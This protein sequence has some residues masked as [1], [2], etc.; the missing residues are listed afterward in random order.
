[1]K[2]A[3]FTHLPWPE[4]NRPG[5]LYESHTQQVIL[6]EELGFHSSSLRRLKFRVTQAL[7]RPAIAPGGFPNYPQSKRNAPANLAGAF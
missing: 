2:F 1:M 5:D 4:D 3:T 7:G 6:A